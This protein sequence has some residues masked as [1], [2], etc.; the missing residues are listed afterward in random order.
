MKQQIT[1]YNFE[2]STFEEYTFADKF[3]HA[4]GVR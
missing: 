2:R 1:V 3:K 4:P